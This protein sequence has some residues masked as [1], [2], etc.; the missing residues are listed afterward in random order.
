[1]I[2]RYNID[3]FKS[4]NTIFI[5]EQLKI[6]IIKGTTYVYTENTKYLDIQL[7]TKQNKTC[8]TST[9]D[10]S[11]RTVSDSATHGL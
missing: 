11:V 6:E 8:A 2:A 3:I 5:H 7:K 4:I 1:M 10:S 9:E